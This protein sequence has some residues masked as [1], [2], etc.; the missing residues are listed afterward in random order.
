MRK[1]LLIGLL[2]SI[3][4][5]NYSFSQP[6][7]GVRIGGPTQSFYVGLL[8][9]GSIHT[10][11]GMDYSGF[12]INIEGSNYFESGDDGDDGDPEEIVYSDL[13]AKANIRLF[14]PRAGIKF[15]F[16][17]K[18][19]LKSYLL[20]EM[21]LVFPSVNAEATDDG[22]KIE[23]SDDDKDRIKDVLDLMGITIGYGTEY[24]F[25]D[26]FSIGGEFGINIVLW[27]WS[28]E[29]TYEDYYD[30]EYEINRTSIDAKANV[31]SSFSRMTL[32]F[33]F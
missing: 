7:M 17:G 28:E 2:L 25:S 31:G 32:N 3:M 24:F 13:E 21:F 14:M 26:Q 11:A 19:N 16:S 29:F 15:N 12:S 30:G 18:N 23:L 8:K 9:L 5:T 10:F 20:G 27:N 22:D 6:S 33:Y 1:T 4:L